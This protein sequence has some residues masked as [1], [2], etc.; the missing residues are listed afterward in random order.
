MA[1]VPHEAWWEVTM[2]SQRFERLKAEFNDLIGQPPDVRA[3][4]LA[5]LANDDADFAVELERWMAA[6]DEAD[7]E[8]AIDPLCGRVL[9]PYV[10]ERRLGAGGMGVV[11]AASRRD[12]V[13]EQRVALKLTGRLHLSGRVQQRIERERAFLARLSHPN[14]AR[15]LDAGTSPELGH[16]FAMELVE[17]TELTVHADAA[18][19]GVPERLRLWL[20]LADAVAYVH[21]HAI[22]HRD[23]K[24]A[25]VL[26]DADGAV[27][28]LDFGIAKL[29]SADAATTATVVGFTAR[30]ASPEQLLGEPVTTATDV[31]ALGL[32]LYE[33]LVGASP[34]GLGAE[35]LNADAPLL[36]D[37]T[38]AA[39]AER[40]RIAA[41]RSTTPRALRQRLR[42]ELEAIVA[43]ALRRD[44]IGRYGSVGEF[45]A[46]VRRH[47]VG[48]P[49][50]ALP[51]SPAYRA[52]VFVRR[53]RAAVAGAALAA[54][55]LFAG[56][57]V[58]LHQRNV[59]LAERDGAE[60]QNAL[61]VSLVSA[62][63]PYDLR[64]SSLTVAEM[65]DTASARTREQ[66]GLDPRLRARLL[67]AIGR[68][69]YVLGRSRDAATAFTAAL[70]ALPNDAG[71]ADALRVRLSLR[72]VA[73]RFE[74]DPKTPALASLA[75]LWPSIER[76]DAALR[77]E[78]LE[79]RAHVQRTL[80]AYEP[81][82]AD[83]ETALASCGAT[84]GDG[85][86]NER[87]A[88]RLK[89]MD[90]L[91]ILRRDEEA[92][93]EADALWSEVSA[94]PAGF[95]GIRVWAGRQRAGVLA[96]AG[97]ADEAERLLA[98]LAPAAERAYGAGST[99]LAAFHS[100]LELAQRKRGRARAAAGSAARAAAI[101]AA[102]LPGS[103]YE[104]YA[105]RIQGDD[106]RVV[107][108]Y[109]SADDRFARAAA[110]YARLGGQASEEVA[111][112]AIERA[113]VAFEAKR[114][115]G[116]YEALVRVG[117]DYLAEAGNTRY[118]GTV[119]AVLAEAALDVGD[120]ARAQL[121]V[122]AIASPGQPS[123]ADDR[124]AAAS[125]ALRLARLQGDRDA[126]SAAIATGRANVR[127][128]DNL[129]V[130]ATFATLLVDEPAADARATRCA[131]ARAAWQE[132]DPDGAAWHVRLKDVPAC[133]GHDGA[134]R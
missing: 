10:L 51:H 94:L 38:G 43:H 68:G 106:L 17:G 83:V 92:L 80:G 75:T 31:Y 47:L 66:A 15:I 1:Y 58:A 16:W 56:L 3:R 36:R 109:A 21:R 128:T 70:Q 62:A 103:V 115:A 121:L 90:L 39:A 11:Y 77:I 59:A 23:L 54:L 118:R 45:A 119:Q 9:G 20:Q 110:I 78:A 76:Q 74:V 95:D 85:G 86:G 126:S 26:V 4:R 124:V 5:Q 97:R 42:G 52:R 122:A 8:P 57:V 46:D 87:L 53:H 123:T 111:W 18:R 134:T 44:A 24:P 131:Q 127:A 7:L 14:V 108:D 64:G 96:M 105:L 125:Y 65:L 27:K 81:A 37:Q 72:D 13:I 98:G 79:V 132:V 104:A 32:L 117:E 99:R 116:A 63:D 29:M 28:L 50:E 69:L 82:L 33:L 100:S 35:R 61:L 91:S 112:C 48:E 107:G 49:V 73:S 40:E 133:A 93:A 25:N 12:G 71:P 55:G 30:Y 6:L 102:N 113:F 130:A 2:D 88:L 114:S 84:C 60:R 34:F 101:Y 19:L 22:V 129:V 89:R 120:A 67:D 41:A